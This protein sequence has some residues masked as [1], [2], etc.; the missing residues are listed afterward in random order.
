MRESDAEG[1]TEPGWEVI[2]R[3]DPAEVLA[4]YAAPIGPFLYFVS[5]GNPLSA[6]EAKSRGMERPVR[7]RGED[8]SP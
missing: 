7:S 8:A 2:I 4:R 5:E 1:E 6:D 3:R